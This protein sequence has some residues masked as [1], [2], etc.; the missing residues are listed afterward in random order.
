MIAPSFSLTAT[1]RV[2][3]KLALDFTTGVLDPRITFTRTT[4]ASNPATYVNNNGIITAATNNQPRFDYNPITLQP[5]GLLI[6]E[7]R[8]NLLKYSEQINSTQNY[9]APNL[10]LTSNSAIAPDGNQTA[11]KFTPNT[12]NTTHSMEFGPDNAVAGTA[13]TVSFFAKEAGYSVV[14]GWNN[15]SGAGWSFNLTTGTSTGTGAT[16]T[17]FGNGWYRCSYPFTPAG[18]YGGV[19]IYV[20]STSTFSGD[21]VSGVYIWGVQF[22][23]GSFLTSYIPTTS[24]ALTRNADVASITG[25]NFSSWWVQTPSSIYAEFIPS[26]QSAYYNILQIDDGT[27]SNRISMAGFFPYDKV[28]YDITSGGVT[29]INAFIPT[30][31]FTVNSTVKAALGVTYG[32]APVSA[33]TNGGSAQNSA[34][35]AYIPPVVLPAGTL[36]LK[37][38]HRTSGQAFLNGTIKRIAYYSQRLTNAEL[39]AITK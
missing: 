29:S 21:G 5:K 32:S 10:I 19:R 11:D 33:S 20:N 14:Y 13:Y 12:T 2:L 37:I 35:G 36:A 39:S 17:S 26:Q 9:Y 30:S 3:P 15:V 27:N 34:G 16:I 24:T 4:G 6:E 28:R 31:E 25:T 7:S 38:G 23:P 22:E 18:T 1:E 8:T